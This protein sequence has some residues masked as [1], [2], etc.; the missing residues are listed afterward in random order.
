MYF[1]NKYCSMQTNILVYCNSRKSK[2]DTD[3]NARTFESADGSV[4]S[5]WGQVT[6]A[7]SGHATRS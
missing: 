4:G 3:T 2:V 5:S 1:F 6:R 7:V